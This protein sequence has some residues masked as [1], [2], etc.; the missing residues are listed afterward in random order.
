SVPELI[1][2]PIY[3]A[4]PLEVQ[5]RVVRVARALGPKSLIFG[6]FETRLTIPGIYYVIDPG[7]AKQNAYNPCLGMN[8]LVVLPVSQ[9]QVRQ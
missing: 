6:L 4:L 7:F 8:S 2:L 3:S 9:A 1:I 5:S